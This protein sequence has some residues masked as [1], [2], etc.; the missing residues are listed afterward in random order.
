MVECKNHQQLTAET[1]SKKE[2]LN[3]SRNEAVRTKAE[4]GPQGN[5]VG[6]RM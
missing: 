5:I 4:T 3:V 2:H 6:A 1:A